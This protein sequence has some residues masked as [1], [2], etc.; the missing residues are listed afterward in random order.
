MNSRGWHCLYHRS[1]FSDPDIAI[2][3]AFSLDGY[4][5]YAADD[6]AANS[7]I[8]TVQYGPVVHGKRERP[9]LYFDAYMN[10][11]AFVTGVCIIPACDP[12]SGSFDPTADCSSSSQYHN[13]DANS[14]DGWYDR[15]YTLVQSL[16]Q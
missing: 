14:P 4:T 5:W 15:T 16:R 2:G 3:H 7:T 12:F 13:C 9:H 10:P 8:D 6:A 1:P 11:I